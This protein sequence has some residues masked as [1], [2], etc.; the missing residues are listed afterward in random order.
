MRL[1]PGDPRIKQPIRPPSHPTRHDKS[2]SSENR[3]KIAACGLA[4]FAFGLG[5]GIGLEHHFHIIDAITG[6]NRAPIA[7]DATRIP[8]QPSATY[9]PLPATP[10][11]TPLPTSTP[12]P[13]PQE[14]EQADT[15]QAWTHFSEECSPPD[16][17][18]Y[19]VERMLQP[20]PDK[21]I[22]A[23]GGV[24][25][26]GFRFTP[27]L[28]NQRKPNTA[29]SCSVSFGSP[30]SFNLTV[31]G[32]IGRGYLLVEDKNGDMWQYVPET[33]KLGNT[34][35]QQPTSLTVTKKIGDKTK[36]DVYVVKGA[37]YVDIVLDPE[38]LTLP[39]FTVTK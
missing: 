13:L 22:A 28:N 30:S 7:G 15:S 3:L 25:I 9:T 19:S 6:A 1:N 24:D 23:R 31:L 21:D 11:P 5:A 29:L 18:G 39:S 12:I 16:S 34:K 32:T 37:R 33:G 10:E 17:T 4:L 38:L 27:P 14:A 8:D 36:G 20:H 35:G 26:V 2:S